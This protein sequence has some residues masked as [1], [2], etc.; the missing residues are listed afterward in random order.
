MNS[1]PRCD[2]GCVPAAVGGLY[3]VEAACRVGDDGDGDSGASQSSC[4]I[5]ATVLKDSA[6]GLSSCALGGTTSVDTWDRLL[7]L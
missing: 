1:A 7:P 4:L 3:A 2:C 6:I 5:A